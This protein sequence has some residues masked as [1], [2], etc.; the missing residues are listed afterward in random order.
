MSHISQ[1]GSWQCRAAAKAPG[2][3]KAGLLRRNLTSF[4]SGSNKTTQFDAN[5]SSASMT[6]RAILVLI[7]L[8]AADV[9][10]QHWTEV[11]SQ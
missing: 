7:V 5:S 9:D 10:V 11:T 2:A 1:K 4:G 8:Y 6:R 3:E